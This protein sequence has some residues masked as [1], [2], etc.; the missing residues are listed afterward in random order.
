MV[1]KACGKGK[2]YKNTRAWLWHAAGKYKAGIAVMVIIQ[3]AFGICSVVFAMLFRNLTDSAVA[4][5]MRI[6]IRMLLV[7]VGLELGE[8][9]LEFWAGYL[10]EW[11]KASLDN[12][13]RERLFSCLLN[14]DYAAVAAV[15]SGEWMNRLTSD[16]SVVTGGMMEIF[17][18]LAGMLARLVG[19]LAAIFLLEPVFLLI[20]IP[21]GLLIFLMTS[22]LRRVLRRLHARIQEANGEV[23]AFLQERLAN[24]MIIR[25]FSME[26]QVR[27]E[28]AQ[29]MKRHRNA[30]MR[31]SLFSSFCSSG[32]GAVAEGGYL[33]GV[34]Y[35]GYGIL[36]G[37]ISYG[38]FAAVLQLVGQIQGPFA[39]IS[40]IIPKYYAMLTSAERLMEAEMF[41]EDG[42]E[43]R[44]TQTEISGFYQEEFQSLGLN[45][46]S[47]S[48]RT[49]EE[50][51]G[52]TM[53]IEHF[54]L[55]I[56]KGEYVAFTGHSGCGKSTL[57]KLLMCLYP[58]DGGNRYVRGRKKDGAFTEY[59]LTTEWRRLFAYVPQGNQLMSGTIRE[60][61]AFGD[62]EAMKEEKRM[63]QA[64]NISCA[65]E[66]VALLEDGLDTLLGEHGYGLS[67]GQMQRIA[68]A[69]AV[70]SDRPILILDEATSSLD[71]MTEQRLLANLRQMTDRTVLII[72]HRP[73]A[74]KICDREVIMM[75][76]GEKPDNPEN[77]SG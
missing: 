29:K 2:I 42:N 57:L 14:R 71:E 65:D 26:E 51:S 49:S 5:E 38:T 35:G 15:H 59:P 24:L 30:R 22:L 33:L 74:L 23:L 64:L 10:S 75:E 3:T 4:G 62:P 36:T 45:D 19:A 73:A 58:L 56:R 50:E 32:F 40:G 60:I 7:M 6:F 70:F 8:I 72:T 28:A 34:A 25:I 52:K 55:D 11:T 63:Q 48:Y 69:R 66:F 61:I 20:L 44:F 77:E 67:E 12:R 13:F 46:A 21:G 37:T 31:R 17:P 47:F 1:M 27:K 76:T 43:K 68:I 16:T 54:D 9:I 39:R 53:V 18:G 41:V